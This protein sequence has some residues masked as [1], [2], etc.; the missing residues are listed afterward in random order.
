[1]SKGKNERNKKGF[2]PRA[3]FSPSSP[4]DIG[5]VRTPWEIRAIRRRRRRDRELAR[6]FILN[7]NGGNKRE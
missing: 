4:H 7:W 1:M 2:P 3:G 6:N 5:A